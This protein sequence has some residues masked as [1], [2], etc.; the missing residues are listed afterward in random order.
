[1]TAYD[2]L[3]LVMKAIEIISGG[4]T[5]TDACDEAGITIPTFEAYVNRTPELQELLAEAERRSYDALADALINIDNHHLHGRSDP[6]MAK[7]ISDNIKWLLSKRSTKTY[8]D[9]IEVTH[10]LTAD[11]AITDAI[12]QGRSRVAQAL[13]A[14][15]AE[16]IDAEF[17][18][19]E[20]SDED[21]MA[22]ILG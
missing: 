15:P 11:R 12:M 9:K 19:V 5:R 3:P 13:L 22:E 16:A 14:P 17:A 1:M 10:N 8:G 7:V 2:Y 21:I 18:V 4:T 20:E 6:K